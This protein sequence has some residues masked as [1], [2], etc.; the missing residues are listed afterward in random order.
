M[1]INILIYQHQPLRLRPGIPRSTNGRRS[2]PK[3]WSVR[4]PR[5]PKTPRPWMAPMAFWL[6]TSRWFGSVPWVFPWRVPNKTCHGYQRHA[7]LI[8]FL[9]RR[10]WETFVKH[11]GKSWTWWWSTICFPVYPGKFMEYLQIKAINGLTHMATL[12]RRIILESPISWGLR[13]RPHK[14]V[15]PAAS[16]SAGQ[17]G[18]WQVGWAG[19]VFAKVV[20]AQPANQSPKIPEFH[21]IMLLL[22]FG[23]VPE[24]GTV[25]SMAP[26]WHLGPG[27]SSSKLCRWVLGLTPA[28]LVY[29]SPM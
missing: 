26:A 22:I 24:A 23:D 28:A 19:C 2:S 27:S 20:Q 1:F 8:S 10:L 17:V 11:L 14:V 12:N 18:W 5:T 29:V 15:P 7:H 6:G 21:I 25:S 9:L 3:S 4:S 16:P 13:P